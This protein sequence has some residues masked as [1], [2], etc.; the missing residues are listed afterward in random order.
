MTDYN[1]TEI[2]DAKYMAPICRPAS[3]EA[4]VLVADIVNI[5]EKADQRQRSRTAQHDSAFRSEVGLIVGDLLIAMEVKEHGWS[6]HPLSSGTFGDRPVSYKTFKPTVD[7]MEAVGLI[8]ISKG[9][10]AQAPQFDE[11]AAPSYHPS[12]ANRFRRT[13]VMVSMAE[14]AGVQS[15]S[16]RK[17]IPQQLPNN[18][19][20]VRGESITVRG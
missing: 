16:A 2:A 15:G 7:K 5:I 8:R 18:V 17:H 14:E 4:K 6:Y 11:R 13:Q 10:N 12:L 3:P 1:I 19:I 9:R 20:K